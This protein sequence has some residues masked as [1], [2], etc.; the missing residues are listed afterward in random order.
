MYFIFSYCYLLAIK[1][2]VEVHSYSGVLT[3]IIGLCYV[4][5]S[6]TQFSCYGFGM[7]LTSDHFDVKYM[8]SKHT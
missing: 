5:L 6:Y 4:F 2:V 1:L 3:L 7:P 8:C